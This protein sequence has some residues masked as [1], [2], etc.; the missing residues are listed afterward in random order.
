MHLHL[1]ARTAPPKSPSS[2]LEVSPW[3]AQITSCSYLRR[4]FPCTLYSPVPLVFS[5][6]RR[7][8]SCMSPER[9]THGGACLKISPPRKAGNAPKSRVLWRH[10]SPRACEMLVSGAVKTWRVTLSHSPGALLQDQLCCR[11]ILIRTLAMRKSTILLHR[12]DTKADLNLISPMTDIWFLFVHC[13]LVSH[14]QTSIPVISPS[15]VLSP[16]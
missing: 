1:V 7:C 8:N 15:S 11:G 12:G 16:L 5:I 9:K 14:V 10:W 6:S 13:L 4:D 2:Y 3:G